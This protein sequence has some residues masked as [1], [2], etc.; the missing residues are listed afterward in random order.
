MPSNQHHETFDDAPARGR[1][2]QLLSGA[3]TMAGL[4][5]SM[6]GNLTPVSLTG[7]PPGGAMPAPAPLPTIISGPAWGEGTGQMKLTPETA[8][9]SAVTVFR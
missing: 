3:Q 8:S 5:D 2:P 1:F 9:K 4:F 6:K 7:K